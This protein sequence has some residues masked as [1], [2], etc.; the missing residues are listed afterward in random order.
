MLEYHIG[1]THVLFCNRRDI[2]GGQANHLLLYSGGRVTGANGEEATYLHL[3]EGGPPH[4]ILG[5]VDTAEPS[6]E[7]IFGH[8]PGLADHAG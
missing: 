6:Y 1:R 2:H 4:A 5:Y 8:P 3:N 7:R